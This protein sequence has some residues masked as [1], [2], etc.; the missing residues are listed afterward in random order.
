MLPLSFNNVWTDCNT[1]CSVNIVDEKI[2]TATNWVN[3]GPV[4]PRTCGSFAWMVRARRLKYAVRW[5]LKV[6]CLVAVA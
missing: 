6:I 1:D 4:T 3:F 2:T 5:F